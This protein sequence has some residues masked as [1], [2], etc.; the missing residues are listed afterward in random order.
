M[1][2]NLKTGIGTLLAPLRGL[3][4]ESAGA[5]NS[6]RHIARRYIPGCWIAAL[7]VALIMLAAIVQTWAT[8]YE[9]NEDGISYL[10]LASAYVH[11]SWTSAINVYWS[12][13]YPALLAP[14][15]VL[16]HS[17]GAEDFVVAHLVNFGCFCI[18][19]LSF[20]FFFLELLRTQRH[21][22]PVSSFSDVP[23]WV[24]HLLGYAL[25]IS[26]SL[27]LITITLVSPDLLLSATV[28]AVLG[29]LLRIQRPSKVKWHAGYSAV[30]GVLLGLGYLGKPVM[31]IFCLAVVATI[32][33]SNVRKKLALGGL[34]LAFL[35]F[36]SIAGPYIAIISGKL[37]RF[38]IGENGRLTYLFVVTRLPYG[39]P[40]G[41]ALPAGTSLKHP[42]RLVLNKPA[43]YEFA[44]PVA[45]SCPI[46][47]D[48]SYWYEGVKVRF[49]PIGQV[50]QLLKSTKTLL[51]IL[52]VRQSPLCV[53]L[54]ALF[55]IS[56]D[57]RNV[58]S[59]IFAQWPL[60]LPATMMIL[61]NL[62]FNLE[63]RHIAPYLTVLW[64]CFLGSLRPRISQQGSRFLQ[65]LLIS[66]ASLLIFGVAVQIG[67]DAANAIRG[68]ST[69]SRHSTSEDRAIATGLHHVG[70][71]SGANVAYVG[72]SISAYWAHIAGLRIVAEIPIED[73]TTFLNAKE[74]TMKTVL[75]A[76]A[77]TGATAL[78][79]PRQP[80][81]ADSG[82]QQVPGTEYYMHLLHR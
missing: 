60:M 4:P 6:K 44:T 15:L 56:G 77:N 75:A 62:L 45:G 68:I 11:H 28:F 59:R 57:T 31:F 5:H 12:P 51:L 52:F 9:M 55:L 50:R 35:V 81:V 49:S 73:K 53:A 34:V 37:H 42:P 30:I 58:L 65:S 70:V 79:A 47:Y 20:R 19:L 78:I 14:A 2:A 23:V 25:F 66:G 46:W 8:R 17:T 21:L 32:L 27:D 67:T 7:C 26:C 10:E 69:E 71:Q 38:T 39:Y 64:A 76:L 33:V 63:A 24:W 48:A 54:I 40:H 16:K 41:V 3:P 29:L 72:N 22:F 18:S 74:G 61:L 80:T 13:L 43:V 82:W 36:A 1:L